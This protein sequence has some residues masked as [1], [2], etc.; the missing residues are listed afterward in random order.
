MRVN[1][2]V[3]AGSALV[4]TCGG[5]Y[6]YSRYVN[7][8]LRNRDKLP[9]GNTRPTIGGFL[10]VLQ[11]LTPTTEN[12]L[13][14]QIHE[15]VKRFGNVYTSWSPIFGA[16]V[17][18]TGLKPLKF[19]L[20]ES[21]ALVNW[22]PVSAKVL[23]GPYSLNSSSGAFH[24]RLRN[25]VT[26]AFQ[27]KALQSYMGPM[28]RLVQKSLQ[29]WKSTSFDADG[30]LMP[31]TI[32]VRKEIQKMTFSLI[33]TIVLGVQEEDKQ[34]QGEMVK[35]FD[36]LIAG[37]FSVPIN[38]SWTLYGKSLKARKEIV[39]RLGAIITE[40]RNNPNVKKDDL[41]EVLLKH[42][43]KEGQEPLSDEQ[44]IDVLI[45]LLFAGFDTV[46]VTLTYILKHLAENRE[47]LPQLY[48]EN[49]AAA[50]KAKLRSGDG[51]LNW[52]DVQGLKYT[53]CVINECLRLSPPVLGNFREV[54][55]DINFNGILI[56]KG[57]SLVY[58]VSYMHTSE[59]YFQ[60]PL[61]FFPMRFMV[62]PNPAH[63]LPFGGG[64][65]MCIG[66]QF[67][68]LEMKLFLHHLV[69]NFDW[70]ISPLASDIKQQLPFCVPVDGVPIE[71]MP[72]VC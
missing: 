69:T 24:K 18:F 67:A 20:N 68:M 71:V 38:Y 15:N 66:W 62:N 26:A 49:V 4:A 35:L 27:P 40:R 46:A 51:D 72:N 65:R 2:A 12:L 64:L 41:L 52:E 1:S 56:P 8:G 13:V 32:I 5:L 3:L 50:K 6:L 21:R 33:V 22:S 34:T 61:K 17:T 55:E 43:T 63:F 11:L 48:E 60:D 7:Q 31:Q 47:T 19:V 25:S 59:E 29:S 23:L 39:S 54:L 14:K 44:I 70:V 36:T 10:G 53:E 42:P 45:N 58:D 37:L 57:W 30:K 28:R 16:V 9:P